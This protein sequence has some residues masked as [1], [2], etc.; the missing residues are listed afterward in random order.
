[1]QVQ[2]AA[3]AAAAAA[4]AAPAAAADAA[5]ADEAGAVAVVERLFGASWGEPQFSGA[6]QRVR[7]A[8]CGGS[9]R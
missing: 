9:R 3:A 4:P 2:A 6:R 1:M 7:Q 5:P 8:Q